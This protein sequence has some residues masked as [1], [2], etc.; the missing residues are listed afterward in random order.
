MAVVIS[1]IG[2]LMLIAGAFFLYRRRRVNAIRDDSLLPLSFLIIGDGSQTTQAEPSVSSQTWP[3]PPVYKE[4][5]SHRWNVSRT[6]RP[7][8]APGAFT[9][10]PSYSALH[11]YEPPS[12][13]QYEGRTPR[14]VPAKT[15]DE[16]IGMMARN[17]S[18]HRRSQTTTIEVAARP[19][20]QPARH[21]TSDDTHIAVTGPLLAEVNNATAIHDPLVARPTLMIPRSAS[22]IGDHLVSASG[23]TTPI[24]VDGG[25]QR[26]WISPATPTPFLP[27]RADSVRTVL[28]IR[29]RLPDVPAV[30][31]AQDEGLEQER[32]IVQS[33]PLPALPNGETK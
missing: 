7:D 21:S 18:I 4:R 17:P 22:A 28:S 31:E 2:V 33:R 5:A 19:F 16:L 3:P 29:K 8:V 1:L 25:A 23:L 12:I 14:A 30:E 27:A 15:I 11:S 6:R 13:A 9:L 32:L 10:P 24:S 26:D 20:P